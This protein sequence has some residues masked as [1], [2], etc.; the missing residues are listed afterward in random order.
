[1][2][3]HVTEYLRPTPQNCQGH[4]RQGKMEKPSQ[5]RGHQRGR[6]TK[7]KCGVLGGIQ[8]QEKDTGGKNGEFQ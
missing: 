6:T 3:G 2:E 7:Y 1:M 4:A 5:P 8:D